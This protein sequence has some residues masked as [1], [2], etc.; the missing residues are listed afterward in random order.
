MKLPFQLLAVLL[1]FVGS[2]IGLMQLT[3]NAIER[4]ET[5]P[6]MSVAPN[7]GFAAVEAMSRSIEKAVTPNR[8]AYRAVTELVGKST[9]LK[10]IRQFVDS[11]PIGRNASYTAPAARIDGLIV[12]AERAIVAS[13]REMQPTIF[14]LPSQL[15]DLYQRIRLTSLRTR[16]IE[17]IASRP[18][19]THSPMPIVAREIP[20]LLRAAQRAVVTSWNA[21]QPAVVALPVRSYPQTPDGLEL[22]GPSIRIARI[23]Q[24]FRSHARLMQSI[25]NLLQITMDN[26]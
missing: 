20:G 19:P 16:A 1:F 22:A 21:L 17:Y 25:G 2:P 4:S 8:I 24:N 5:Y 3:T 9:K 11:G 10:R 18:I 13:T 23:A 14:A 6:L 15:S 26:R 12:A 7:A